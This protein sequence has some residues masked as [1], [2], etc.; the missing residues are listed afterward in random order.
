MFKTS[1]QNKELH[2]LEHLASLIKYCFK[3]RNIFIK[4]TYGSMYCKDECNDKIVTIVLQSHHQLRTSHTKMI[5]TR[6]NYFPASIQYFN[7]NNGW[8]QSMTCLFQFYFELFKKMLSVERNCET[9]ECNHS[10]PYN[11]KLKKC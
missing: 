8:H 1:C 5:L 7:I 10:I 6:T 11:C 2:N 9:V 4:K 3:E